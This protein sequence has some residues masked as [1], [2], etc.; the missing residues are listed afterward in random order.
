MSNSI[1]LAIQLQGGPMRKDFNCEEHNK[2]Q[3]QPSWKEKWTVQFT[4]A[5]VIDGLT[6]NHLSYALDNNGE[7]EI[8]AED[9]KTACAKKERK[10]QLCCRND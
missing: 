1:V 10:Q 2:S 7:S 5:V 9:W 3:R 4:S 6:L 8:I